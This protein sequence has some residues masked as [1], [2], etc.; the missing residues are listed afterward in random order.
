M[1]GFTYRLMA[2]V[3]LATALPAAL[4]LAP[5]V[6]AAQAPAELTSFDIP[7]LP[8]ADALNAFSKQA[9]VQIL[10]PYEAVAG[11][12]SAPL[13]A[14][15]SR[16]DAL[17]KLIAG[18]GLELVS[19]DGRTVT[20]RA[21]HGRT[22]DADPAVASPHAVNEVV[23][24]ASARRNEQS[25]AVHRQALGV[26]DA[27]TQDDTG[28][29][30]DQTV[31]DALIR[32]PGI[33]TM[34][35]LYGEQSAKYVS[36]RGVS[37][38]L[39]AVTLDGIGLYSASNDGAG[40]RRVDLQLIPTQVSKEVDVFKSFTPDL[41]AGVIGGLTNIVP[42]SALD[43]KNQ[44][45]LDVTVE[46]RPSSPRVPGF[47]SPG[48][49]NTPW[50]GGLKGLYVHKFGSNDQFGVVASAVY[51]QES[52]T[53]SK[54]NI[55]GRTYY[56]A[57]GAT[58]AANLSNWNGYAPLPTLARPMHYTKYRQLFGG[59]VGLEYRPFDSLKLSLSFYDYKQLENQSLSDMY[60]ESFTGLTYT[61]PTTATF[62]I[63]RVRPAFDY[64][65]FK[66]ESRGLQV[67]GVED[68]GGGNTLEVRGAYG[69][70]SFYD[71]DQ[72]VAYASAPTN[73][74]ISFDMSKPTPTFTFSNPADMVDLS[75]FTN[76]SASDLY[77]RTAF[78]SYEG[79][80]DF[81][82]NYGADTNGFGLATGLDARTV[83]AK[84]N[85]DQIDYTPAGQLG[86]LGTVVN[87]GSFG[88]GGYP[89]IFLDNEAFNS[90]VKPTLAV[91]AKQTSTDSLSGD[92]EYDE[93]VLA[94]YVAGMYAFGKTRVIGGLRFENAKYTAWVPQSVA[95]V[96]V[97]TF[98]QYNGSYQH[99]LPSASVVHDLTDDI[100]LRAGYSQTLGRPAFSDIAQAE[101]R[102]D[103]ALT[104][105][106]GNPNLKPRESSNY[107]VA[108]EY[109][110]NGRDGMVSLA[111][112]YKDIKHDI[113]ALATTQ[114]I[115]G[116]QYTV[117][118]PQNASGSTLKGVEAQFVDNRIAGLP[119]FLHNKLG[120]SLNVTRMWANMNY[121]V[122][123]VPQERNGMLYQPNWLANGSLFYKLPRDGEIRIAYNWADK[124]LNTVNAQIWND[125]VLQARGQMNASVRFPLRPNLILKLEGDNLLGANQTMDHGYFSERYTLTV[126]RV[127]F[128][129]LVWT[130]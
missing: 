68:F 22:T 63:G 10:F 73:D 67:K 20:L 92:Y 128:L 122:G 5:S 123:G 101:V 78:N 77:S 29:L 93:T 89:S 119:G 14:R 71:M 13:R 76:Y 25:I 111:G 7:G 31:A 74:F 115:N 83:N 100:K 42:Y 130:H 91:N 15:L 61:S 82:H 129:D 81:K 2:S 104:I 46:N 28:D 64:D 26:A 56:T 6:A 55:N 112:F 9:G 39:N 30:A 86:N 8:L 97:G 27:V 58:A 110:F 124:S 24:T 117:T 11:R 65:L 103:S 106:R 95:G 41:D 3:A 4:V 17:A 33:S 80:A 127:F 99:V 90:Q 114:D 98:G 53:A 84:R 34:Q 23:V 32:L 48:F 107:D 79:R 40:T 126:D 69:L 50:G 36:V 120:I 70:S 57:T 118:T 35:T 49:V 45:N 43:G 113:Y 16:Q 72:G 51:N 105:S 116:V 94:G 108:A 21:V 75:K 88:F 109:Y 59:Y 54:P 66:T 38:D 87:F 62:K 44:F 47:N 102:N 121:L 18:S 19:D 12:A 85:L 125:Y 37:P 60:A 1:T 52:W 96:Y